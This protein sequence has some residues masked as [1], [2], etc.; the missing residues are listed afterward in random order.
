MNILQK[1]FLAFLLACIPIRFLFVY[2][3]KTISPIYLPYL[4]LLALLPAIGFLT[5]YFGGIYK[6]GGE[7]FGQKIWWNDLR[8]VHGL[9]YICFSYLA[10]NKNKNAFVPLLIDV[11]IGLFSFM[12]YHFYAGSFAKIFM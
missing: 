6:K 10:I 7:T 4:G 9:L 5:I 1:R 3:A 2:I 12:I 11:G 8:P